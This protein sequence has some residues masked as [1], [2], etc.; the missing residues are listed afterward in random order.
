VADPAWLDYVASWLGLPWDNA[1][2]TDQKRRILSRGPAIVRGYSTRGGLE[3][4]LECLIAGSPR[5]FRI[6]DLSA[7]YGLVTLAGGAGSGSRLPALLAGLPS[8]TTELGASVLLGRARLPCGDPEPM[9]ARLVGRIRI[10]VAASEVERL[11][12]SPWLP[13]LIDAM[14]PAT[15]RA[16]LRWLGPAGLHASTLADHEISDDPTAHLGNDSIT[17]SSRLGGR[18]RTILPNKLSGNSTLQ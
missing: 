7:D 12:W 1:L 4:L 10:D 18:S 16:E 17:G 11:A 14:L 8:T 6:T 13:R 5:R 2:D 9:T 3:A 15:A